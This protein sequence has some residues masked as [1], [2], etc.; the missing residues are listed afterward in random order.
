MQNKPSAEKKIKKPGLLSLLKP[1]S[2]LI[3]LLLIFTLLS[4]AINLWL[5]KIIANSIDAFTTGHFAFRHII[6]EFSVA[7]LCILIFTYLQSIIQTYSSERVARDLRNRLSDKISKQNHAFI[8]SAN[9]AK[10]LTNLTADTDSIKMFISQAIVSI[11]SSVFII[12]GA[13]IL[14]ISINW[15]LALCVIAII[16]IIGVTFFFVLRKVRGL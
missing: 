12:I 4:N 7:V 1:Y 10:L 13:S 2:G 9:P 3:A 16:P 14:L 8:E 5:P 11:I 15:K 6:M